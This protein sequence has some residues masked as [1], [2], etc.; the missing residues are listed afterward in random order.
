MITFVK[1]LKTN[2]AEIQEK[3]I[4]YSILIVYSLI[5]LYLS[6]IQQGKGEKLEF[7]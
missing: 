5:A 4:H 7:P 2:Q 3:C 1:L 6:Y